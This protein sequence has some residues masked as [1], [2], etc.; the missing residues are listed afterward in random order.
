V[1]HGTLI[2]IPNGSFSYLPAPNY[3]GA[4]S[5]TYKASDGTVDSNT[6]TVSIDVGSVND[7]PVAVADAYATAED[8]QLNVAALTGVL[9]NDEDI[10]NDTL[11]SVLVTNVSHGSLTLNTDGSFSYLP[12]ANYN[13]SD[14]FTYK[15]NDGTA[16]SNIVTVTISISA[17]NDPPQGMDNTFTINE[18]TAKTFIES[19]FGFSDPYDTPP[20]ILSVVKIT[21][22]PAQGKLTV[23]GVEVE[24]FQFVSKSEIT[25]G[26]FVFTPIANQNGNGYASFTFAVVDNALTPDPTPNTIT[27]N[28]N[29]VNDA[30]VLAPIGNKTV[31]EEILLQFDANASDIDVPADPL[32]FSL[33]SAPTGAVIDPDTGEFNWTPTEAQGPSPTINDYSFSVCVFDGTVSICEMIKVTVNEVNDAPSGVS[34]TVTILEDGSKTFTALDFGFTDLNDIPANTLSAVIIT[35]LPGDGSL[36]LGSVPV[37]LNQSIP[38]EQLT[39]LVFAPHPNEYG[40]PYAA[41]NFK[42]RDDGEILNGVNTDPVNKTITFNVTSV[43]DTPVAN[44]QPVST[45]EDTNKAIILTGSDTEGSLLTY[46]IVTQPTHGILIGSPPNVT[47]DPNSNYNGPDSFTFRVNDGSLNSAPAAVTIN[48][49]PVND[50]PVG[51]A[52][53]YYVNSIKIDTD[54]NGTLD[55]FG[56]KIDAPGVLQNDSDVDQDALQVVLKT[57]PTKGTVTLNLNGSFLYILNESVVDG[58]DT[59]V[60]TIS[61]GHGGTDDVTV[62][63]TIDRINPVV[64]IEWLKPVTQAN[65]FYTSYDDPLLLRVRLSSTSDVSRVEFRWWN[66][67]VNPDSWVIVSDQAVVVSQLEYSYT[68]NMLTLPYLDDIQVYAYAFDAAGNFERVKFFII[69]KPSAFE[70]FLPLILR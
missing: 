10:E 7:A 59:F 36:N 18:D 32:T 34:K 22:L 23:D 39:N 50:L 14:S 30:P 45:Q 47:Y 43:N 24:L 63:L 66:T 33:T 38:V 61:D 44:A 68:L 6:A 62:T 13:G 67:S 25:S 53:Q 57:A 16:D 48:V 2:L 60:Y 21:S 9:D 12:A 11:T 42:V 15:A 28:V 20:N 41:F 54:N 52:D 26:K 5:F 19:D 8:T 37:V 27:I 31:N 35:L 58:V 51:V 65:I 64:T 4:D 40:T 49:T 1:D 55:S 56:V 3:Y 29:A 70:V 46:S 69:H 17:V